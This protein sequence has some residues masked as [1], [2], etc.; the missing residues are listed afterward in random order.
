MNDIF[1]STVEMSDLLNT[2]M[3]ATTLDY[4]G[5]FDFTTPEKSNTRVSTC[6]PNTLD[7]RVDGGT[8][9]TTGYTV[10]MQRLMT[11]TKML[12]SKSND[13][14]LQTVKAMMIDMAHGLNRLI[15]TTQ[16][17]V[18]EVSNLKSK[19]Q[20]IYEKQDAVV[21]STTNFNT[22]GDNIVTQQM[23]SSS[24]TRQVS[25]TVP[26]C[27][28][29]SCWQNNN[30]NEDMGVTIK[31]LRSLCDC[32]FPPLASKVKSDLGIILSRHIDGYEDISTAGDNMLII[33]CNANE[34]VLA[35]G[36]VAITKTMKLLGTK[37]AFML[38]RRLSDLL[39]RV[40]SIRDGKV[41]MVAAP[42]T[43]DIIG[44]GQ[45]YDLVSPNLIDTPK[46]MKGL[47][48]MHSTSPNN[49]TIRTFMNCIKTG[50]LD[51]NG[52]FYAPIPTSSA[53]TKPMFPT[54]TN[55][56]ELN[57]RVFVSTAKTSM[58]APLKNKH[59]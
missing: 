46:V 43:K 29:R 45:G 39:S 40:D 59:G 7:A 47:K 28:I 55:G 58:F 3:K 18:D 25:T 4:N 5:S 30:P 26:A 37:Y 44:A 10:V 12:D 54:Y 41:M 38:P 31:Y 48:A 51:A 8:D 24:H 27:I 35:D 17:L 56:K 32:V 34:N 22:S 53:A 57:S 16:T 9:Y 50:G 49:A 19:I 52:K 2:N 13:S 36:K 11:V 14:D 6:V 1:G 20:T 42:N 15:N 23:A 33:L 21:A